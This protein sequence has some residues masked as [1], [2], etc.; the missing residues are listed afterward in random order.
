MDQEG[1]GVPI[2]CPDP[3]P[4]DRLGWKIDQVA[5][6]AGGRDETQVK[7]CAARYGTLAE[8]Q[9]GLPGRRPAHVQ[10]ALASVQRSKLQSRPHTLRTIE[11]E[12]FGGGSIKAV[13]VQDGRG[14]N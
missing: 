10:Q 6:F 7:A 1:D 4:C 13:E 8:Q 5:R 14:M 9:D 12:L 3:A 2:R 11:G